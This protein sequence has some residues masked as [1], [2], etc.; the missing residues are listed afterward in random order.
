MLTCDDGGVSVALVGSEP[1]DHLTGVF[2]GYVLGAGL[3]VL[4]HTGVAAHLGDRT[5]RTRQDKVETK[6]ST[7]L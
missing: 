3:Q 2:A 7:Q 4:Q 1:V 6:Q 5:R